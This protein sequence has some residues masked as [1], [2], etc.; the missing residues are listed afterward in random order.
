MGAARIRFQMSAGHSEEQ[1]KQA[2]E[3]IIETGK[4]LEI[5]Q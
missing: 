5:I 1:V 4:D 3:K 2:I